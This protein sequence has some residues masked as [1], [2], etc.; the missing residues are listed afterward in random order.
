MASSTARDQEA[1]SSSMPRCAYH[2]FL[3]FRGKDLRKTF[4]DHLH[5]ALS[6]SGIHT[7]RDDDEIER[8][9]D[10]DSELRKAIEQSRVSII[11]FSKGYASSRWCLDELVKI[12]ERNKTS[13]QVVLP[14]FYD[15]DPSQVR[16]QT[17]AFGEAFDRHEEESETAESDGRRKERMEMVKRWREALT[18]VTN[19]GGKVLQNE[20]DGHES[21][22]IQEIVQEVGKKL[23][24]MVLMVTQYPVGIDFRVKKINLW[25]QDTSTDADIGVICG[26]GGIGKTTIAKTVYNLNFERFKYSSFLAN[27]KEASKQPNGLVRLQRQLLRD[28]LKGKKQKISS[29]DE[30]IMKI[31]DAICCKKVFVV[32]DDVDQLD[33]LNSV[34]G[35]RGWLYP[36]SKIIITTRNERLLK[37]Y[38]AC[39][40][41]KVNELDSKES[42]Q[43]FC[44]HAFGQDHPIEGYAEHSRSVLQHCGGLPLALQVLGSSFRGKS[45]EV[46]E[47]ALEKLEAIPDNLILEKLAVSYESLQD[48]LDKKLFLYIACFFIGKDKECVVKILDECYLY[49]TVGI[50]N[51]MDRC[52]I[53]IENG[54][55]LMMHQ[56]LQEMAREIIHKESP[57]IPGKRSI[58]CHQKDSFY[59]LS[60]KTGT[61]SVQGLI[62][63][64]HMLREE[65]SSTTNFNVNKAK[66][67]HMKDAIDRSNMAYQGNSPKRRRIGFLSWQPI[68]SALTKLFPV[69]DEVNLTTDAFATMQKLRLLQ[70]NYMQLN[71]CYKEFPKELRWLCWHGFP[72]KS[73]PSNFNM[74]SLVALDMQNSSLTRV[75]TGTKFLRLL[76]FLNLGYSHSLTRT[77]DFS[78]LPSLERLVL[79][80]CVSLVKVHESIGGLEKLVCLNLR[81]CKSLGKLPREIGG[82][83]S[84]EKLILSGCS[85]LES[86]P[87]ELEKL[88]SLTALHAHKTAIIQSCLTSRKRDSWPFLFWSMASKPSKNMNL[89][90][91]SLPCTLVKLRIS[92]CNLSDESIPRDF[93]GLSSLL[94]LDLSL[95]PI[96]SLPESIR[97][98]TML[99]SLYL[100]TC[101]SLQSLPELPSSLKEII[102][103]DCKSLERMTMLPRLLK[104]LDLMLINGCNKLI[105]VDG[106]F[107]LEPLG[108]LDA[109]IIKKLGLVDLE[110]L[111]SIEVELCNNLTFTR[112]KGPLQGLF[113][114]GIFSTFFPGSG[115]PDW[116]GNRSIGPLISFTVPLLFNLEIQGLRVCVTY[117]RSDRHEAGEFYDF[118][119]KISNKTKGLDWTYGPMFY[120]NEQEDMIWL[121]HWNVANQFKGG[122]EV[123][124]SMVV[125]L[126]FQVKECGIDLVYDQ[127]E[128]CTQS[129]S[130]KELIQRSAYPYYQNVID[131]DLSPYQRGKGVYVLSHYDLYPD[132]HPPPQNPS[133]D[134]WDD[135]SVYD[136]SIWCPILDRVMKK[137]TTVKEMM[138]TKRNSKISYLILKY[139]DRS[140]SFLI[141]MELVLLLFAIPGFRTQQD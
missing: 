50:R 2:A 17:G 107:K 91:L 138:M 122:D 125:G 4:I 78:G 123:N 42:L 141:D 82:L 105:K 114:F 9:Q 71:G 93:S 69:P 60:T 68:A 1:S 40:M 27:I 12:V 127:E 119:I 96:S 84:L 70:L 135:P 16:N 104:S 21:M 103:I 10:I 83:K 132:L 66:R 7:F 44:W 52:L 36:G 32:L 76:K 89:P 24:R 58:L 38:E 92:E 99:K 139:A 87:V 112:E 34:F 49:P 41:F 126:G 118:Y 11:V 22:F 137:K 26:M 48:D 56:L 8:G 124:V 45:V 33:Q 98:L 106:L 73:I 111:G 18:E 13:G 128:K 94:E 72:L 67:H 15:V 29:V 79:K 65:K 62:L 133:S 85:N 46:W 57:E 120:G 75:W 140:Y 77:P 54:N 88:E 115:V 121:S 100:D 131:G 136:P 95:N 6:Q 61:E 37:A 19:L 130:G 39:K 20:A 90:L 28:I 25:L 51:L 30:G 108:N 102:L 81:G 35:M 86:L 31:K 129:N 110:S 80:Y 55:K 113:E 134:R 53:T 74:E 3:S 101:R 5:T 43:L 64:M 97:N 109:K 47:S 14:V 117:V 23:N 59:V 63:N 116:F